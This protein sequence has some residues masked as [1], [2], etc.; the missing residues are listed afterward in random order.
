MRHVTSFSELGQ[1]NP[2]PPSLH[3]DIRCGQGNAFEYALVLIDLAH[4]PHLAAGP[5]FLVIEL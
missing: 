2:N 3:L 1:L 5:D 4:Q